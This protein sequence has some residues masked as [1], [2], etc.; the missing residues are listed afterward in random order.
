MQES[1]DDNFTFKDSIKIEDESDIEIVPDYNITYN[2]DEDPEFENTYHNT[3]WSQSQLNVQ[4]ESS[5]LN[6]NK[7]NS[8]EQNDNDNN[9]TKQILSCILDEMKNMS[10]VLYS[11]RGALEIQTE[12][13]KNFKK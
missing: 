2:D 13:L 3:E 12:L 10:T 11:I 6:D 4:A 8:N 9:S 5:N 7:S 1:S